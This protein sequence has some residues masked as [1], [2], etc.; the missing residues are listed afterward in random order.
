MNTRSITLS[1]KVKKEIENNYEEALKQI[2]FANLVNNLKITKEIGKKYTS[3]IND[4][5]EELKKCKNC[6]GLFMCQNSIEGHVFFP[7]KDE[8]DL[9]FSYLPCKYYKT[10]LKEKNDKDKKINELENARMK[11]IDIKDK[12]RIKIIKWLKNFYDNY[13]KVN[14]LKGLY[15]HG[16]FGSGK[17]FLIACLLNELKIKKNAQIEII[18]FPELLRNMKEDF[19]LVEDKLNYLQNVDILLIDDIGAEKVTEWG[20]DEILGTILQSRMNDRLTTFFT[21]NL[22]IEE[23]ERHL[24]LSKGSEDFVKARRIIE[25]IKQLTEDLELVSKNRR[26]E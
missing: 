21:S 6:K 18:Y 12:N 26:N 14:S 16:S 22:T 25:R 20:R 13:T 4:T 7:E 11:D 2:E 5:V 17:T 10:F 24:S 23:L 3:K 8:L 9:K 1:E 19:S 15:L